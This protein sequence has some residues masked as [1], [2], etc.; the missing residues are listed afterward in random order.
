MLGWEFPPYYSGGL[1]I[2]ISGLT[3]SLAKEDVEVTLI[4]PKAPIIKSHVKLIGANSFEAL[5][6]KRLGKMFAVKQ[7]PSLLS[8]YM[9]SQSYSEEYKR[10]ME[11][12]KQ[13][14]AREFD[15]YGRNLYEEVERFAAIAEAISETCEFDVIH[16]HDWMTFPAAIR[17]KQKSGRPLVIHMH[18]TV[19]DRGAGHG[20]DY[21]YS[22]ERQGF[23]AADRVIAISNYVKNTITSRYFIEPNKVTVVHNG[24]ELNEIPDVGFE[25]YKIKE[26]D[27]VVLSLGRI[28]I[29]KGLDYL[30]YAARKVIDRYPDVKFVIV[31]DGDMRPWMLN[32]A[33]ELGMAKNF[34]FTG[35][36][37]RVDVERAFRMADL[38]IMPSVSEPFGLVALEAMRNNVP[39]IVSKQSGAS[40]VVNHA[41]KVDFWDVDEMANK[42]LGVLKYDVCKEC[43][44]ENGYHEVQHLTWDTPARK[45]ITVYNEVRG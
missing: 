9:T 25:H 29:Q 4:C 12:L 10:Q 42:I 45:C 39:V 21:E 22:I 7:V 37:G 31:G 2:A 18:N 24:I 26:K 34:I 17:I 36:L 23:L 16:A 14:N 40:E 33:T 30:V 3:K 5:Y 28:T 19:F 44:G 32:K 27:K 1:G 35:W 38:F 11:M 41:M 8:P 13:G 20:N 6:V 15:L 43:M